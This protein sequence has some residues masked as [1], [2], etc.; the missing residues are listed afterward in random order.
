MQLY[1][2]HALLIALGLFKCLSGAGWGQPAIAAPI[3]ASQ[4]QSIPP[5]NAIP[6]GEMP[7]AAT[8]PQFLDSVR[9]IV[10]AYTD[11]LPDFTCTQHIQRR[12]KFGA[13]GSWE[14]VDQ[15]V[16]EVSYHE[17]GETYKVLTIDKK[18]PPPNYD[19]KAAGFSSVG[20]FGNGLYLLFAPESNATFEMEGP[21][22]TRG[23]KTVRAR[24]YVPQN[25][26]RY[27]FV[28]GDQKLTTAYSGHCWIDL[29]TR[30][31]ARYECV[32]QDI[33]TS[34]PVRKSSRTIEYALTEIA[35]T[36][37]WLPARTSVVLQLVNEPP[38]PPVDFYMSITGRVGSNIYHVVDAV[39][40]I[41]YKN[42]RKFGTEV[43]LVPE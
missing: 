9:Q 42:Y 33:P 10:M 25:S 39:N 11:A 13:S 32:A 43:R 19:V 40:E 31:V 34:S 4:S 21:D 26:S 17:K 14:A 8:W 20:D 35:G 27:Q 6:A 15:I 29:A 36:R 38:R 5:S 23:R 7:T 2:S 37:Y 16:A 30:H 18:P 24:F 1:R 12:A 28:L 41:E 3:E 22:R